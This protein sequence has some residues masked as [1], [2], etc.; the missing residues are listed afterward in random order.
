MDQKIDLIVCSW[1]IIYFTD[2]LGTLQILLNL[3]KSSSGLLLVNQTQNIQFKNI[4]GDSIAAGSKYLFWG[5]KQ[6]GLQ[7]VHSENIGEGHAWAIKRS[8]EQ[9]IRLPFSYDMN[10]TESPYRTGVG[11]ELYH[12][13]YFINQEIESKANTNAIGSWDVYGNQSLHDELQGY[14]S[15]FYTFSGL[16]GDFISI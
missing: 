5:L 16:D 15:N 2:P 11:I 4:K 12:T 14:N 8:R 9:K 1:T 3:L 13:H 6:A 7:V 10:P